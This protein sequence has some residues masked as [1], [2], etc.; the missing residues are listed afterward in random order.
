MCT[1]LHE[2]QPLS[3]RVLQQ[4]NALLP[5]RLSTKPCLASPFSSQHAADT[6]PVHSAGVAA[7]VE[8]VAACK[9]SASVSA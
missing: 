3:A 1:G 5:S 4:H 7:P 2:L 6:S 9:S 8:Q